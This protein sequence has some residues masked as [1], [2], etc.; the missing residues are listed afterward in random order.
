MVVLRPGHVALAE[1]LDIYRGAK[2]ALDPVARADVE[3]GAAA[4]AAIRGQSIDPQSGPPTD[5]RPD[6]ESPGEALPASIARLALALK[7]A[8]LAQG[9]SGVRWQI[10]D[11]LSECLAR[12][13]LPVLATAAESSTHAGMEALL[14]GTGDVLAGGRRCS[15]AGALKESGL[16]PLALGPDE[17]R[18][19][20]SGTHV[21]TAMALASL[22]E[23]ERV[24]QSGLVA[25]A[26]TETVL[27]AAPRFRDPRL[28]G[29]NRRSGI[30][31]IAATF[32]KLAAPRTTAVRRAN[33][34]AHA[35]AHGHFS[36]AESGACL[37][38][39]R[40]AGETLGRVA[41]S[42]SEDRLVVWQSGEIVDSHA[43]M[44]SQS[45]AADLV[46]LAFREISALSERRI[47]RLAARTRQKADGAASPLGL[48]ASFLAEIR[49]RAFPAGLAGGGSE[50]PMP[51]GGAQRLLPMAGTVALVVLI[52]FLT[53]AKALGRTE[54]RRVG[55]PLQP[56]LALL[57]DRLPTQRSAPVSAIDLAGAAD[58]VRSG[59]LAAA[60]GI[61]LPSVARPR[62][63]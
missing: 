43:D 7:L 32:P 35:V 46:A 21:A 5:I 15:A 34:A 11:M 63:I 37:D 38:L 53:A 19:L 59:A 16:P 44:A 50:A 40:Q 45:I 24:F 28:P 22:F 4:L 14:A 2:V 48:A 8:S 58:L 9:L 52:E 47:A 17:R 57:R 41:N 1:W 60:P 29:F 31:E 27:E 39:L 10:V 6:H 49:E 33:G 26:L 12:D 61:P 51:A 56:V 55:D 30:S 18:A 20:A 36:E 54:S 42:V 3:A 25:A 13:L 62:A 23:A